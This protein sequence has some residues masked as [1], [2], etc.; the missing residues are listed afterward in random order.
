MKL[1]AYL[2]EERLTANKFAR[3]AELHPSTVYRHL[4]GSPVRNQINFEKII[5]AT[6]GRV[7]AHD[8]LWLFATAPKKKAPR[9]HIQRS[10]VA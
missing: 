5:R 9:R 3:Q 10:R 6:N 8:L 7:T 1:A 4:A 2:E